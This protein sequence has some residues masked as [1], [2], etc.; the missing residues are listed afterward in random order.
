MLFAA[1]LTNCSEDKVEMA[2]LQLVPEEGADKVEVNSS[3][4]DLLVNFDVQGGKVSF[5]VETN[6]G[7]W[8]YQAPESLDWLSVG[9]T[10]NILNIE[11]FANG[12]LDNKTATVTIE[13]GG[14]LRTVAI[15]QAAGDL[16]VN[17]SSIEIGAEGGMREVEVITNS[18]SGWSFEYDADWLDISAEGAKLV[19]NAESHSSNKRRVAEVILTNN[20]SGR[21]FVLN[22]L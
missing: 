9:A 3:T 1:I 18:V 22:V 14:I 11:V 15:K 10:G 13:A 7:S 17:P 20:D 19:I 12:S 8:D 16:V 21:D 5:N 6:Q 4:D 2:N